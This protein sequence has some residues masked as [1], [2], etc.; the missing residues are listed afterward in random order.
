MALP[1]NSSIAAKVRALLAS[2]V[3]EEGINSY[4]DPAWKDFVTCESKLSNDKAAYL[5]K[6]SRK[7]S[8]PLS[9]KLNYPTFKP[10]KISW[11]EC[12]NSTNPCT[13]SMITKGI[14]EQNAFWYEN[15]FRRYDPPK[16]V[17][18]ALSTS[19]GVRSSAASLRAHPV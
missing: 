18:S 3:T 10:T 14:P 11:G 15:V 9:L 7:L 1:K 4:L 13:R 2:T 6:P 5:T 8:F 19:N 17:S 12:A 16:L